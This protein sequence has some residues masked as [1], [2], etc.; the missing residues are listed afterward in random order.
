MTRRFVPVLVGLG[1]AVSLLGLWSGFETRQ[2]CPDVPTC[3]GPRGEYSTLF[4]SETRQLEFH[5]LT[6]GVLGAIATV[7]LG[8]WRR[9]WWLAAET[10]VFVALTFF[11]FLAWVLPVQVIY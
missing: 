11:L 9:N 6:G 10:G 7:A 1:I 2:G 8:E 5:A 4:G 3:F